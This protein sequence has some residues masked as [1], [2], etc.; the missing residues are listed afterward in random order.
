[1]NE[2]EELIEKYDR[3]LN[4]SKQNMLDDPFTRGEDSGTSRV[5]Y[6]ILSDLEQVK[7]SLPTT[8]ITE[9]QA[10]KKIAE[11]T[12]TDEPTFNPADFYHDMRILFKNA[13]LSVPI[14][15]DKTL[16]DNGYRIVHKSSLPTQQDKVVVKQY[17]AD[18]YEENKGDLTQG[19]FDLTKR[20]LETGSR[21]E[22]TEMQ[23][24]L[25]DGDVDLVELFYRMKDGYTVKKEQMYWIY[26]PIADQYLG[27]D[28]AEGKVWWLMKQNDGAKAEL[29]DAEITTISKQY[30]A[31]AVP[32]EEEGSQ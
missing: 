20:A 1:M 16:Y 2:I 13:D 3:I 26:D 4:N 23:N 22:R 30:K 5:S 32:V 15:G 31:F 19:I 27:Y 18:W 8:E 9:L 11:V 21:N 6:E 28:R 25:Y 12:D 29:T 7:S 24:L 17:I 14:R 10:W